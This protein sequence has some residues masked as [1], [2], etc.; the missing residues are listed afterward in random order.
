MDPE[1]A[2]LHASSSPDTPDRLSLSS[3]R[4]QSQE[5]YPDS[6]SLIT[7][8]RPPSNFDHPSF[9]SNPPSYLHAVETK[10][11]SSS[12]NDHNI[13]GDNDRNSSSKNHGSFSR[14]PVESDEGGID[15]EPPISP[16]QYFGARSLPLASMDEIWQPP[17]P[18]S[19][20]SAPRSGTQRSSSSPSFVHT[21]PLWKRFVS[22]D[23]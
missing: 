7:S 18:L 11:H 9:Q 15:D 2:I 13:W 14:S 20:M 23:D 17:I 19:T 8:T 22:T 5:A 12:G 10:R 1:S 21:D 16:G 4:Q 3:L 6:G